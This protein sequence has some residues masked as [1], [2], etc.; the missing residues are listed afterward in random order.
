MLKT[1]LCF[2]AST[3]GASVGPSTRRDCTATWH[4]FLDLVS[5]RFVINL[6]YVYDWLRYT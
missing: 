4:A 6:V 2:L 3:T 1:L 5:E